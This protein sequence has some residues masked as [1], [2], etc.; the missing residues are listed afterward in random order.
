MSDASHWNLQVTRSM[1]YAERAEEC[2]LMAKV[3]PA[4]LREGFLEL[5][6]EY[7]QLAKLFEK[8][9]A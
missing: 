9:A 8:S 7:E 6:A 2:R 5:A 3:C 1:T 4:H